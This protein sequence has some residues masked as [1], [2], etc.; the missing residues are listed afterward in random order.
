MGTVDRDVGSSSKAPSVRSKVTRLWNL[1]PRRSKIGEGGYQHVIERQS[2]LIDLVRSVLAETQQGKAIAKLVCTAKDIVNCDRIGFFMVE[3]GKGLVCQIAPSGGEAGWAVEMGRGILGRVAVTGHTMR[4]DDTRADPHFDPHVDGRAGPGVQS[5]LCVPLLDPGRNEVV[6]V[7]QAINKRRP[8]PSLESLA[9]PSLSV[10]P[11]EPQP[12]VAFDKTDED[13]LCLLLTLTHSKLGVL[14]LQDQKARALQQVESL[15]ALVGSLSTRITDVD[16][17]LRDLCDAT[18]TQLDCQSVVVYFLEGTDLVCR[19]QSP[20]RP[21]SPSAPARSPSR[22][23]LCK[24]ELGNSRAATLR[25]VLRSG[26]YRL[27]DPRDHEALQTTREALRSSSQE[28]AETLSMLVSPLRA[29]GNVFGIVVAMNKRAVHD[30]DDEVDLGHTPRAATHR[31]LSQILRDQAGLSSLKRHGVRVGTDN[32][33][34]VRFSDK[35]ARQL[36]VLLSFAG[37]AVQTAEMYSKQQASNC[38]L[39]ALLSLSMDS[40]H[41][42]QSGNLQDI[43]FA[44]CRHGREVFNCD[45]FSFFAVDPLSDELLGWFASPS[46]KD[47]KQHR[48]AKDGVV[49][50]CVKTG[51]AVNIANAWSDPRFDAS[52]DVDT[53]YKTDTVLCHPIMSRNSNIVAALQCVNK[54]TGRP[55][56]GED[57]QTFGVLS[58][59]FADIIENQVPI[60]CV[61][62]MMERTDVHPDAKETALLYNTAHKPAGRSG[63][64]TKTNT[65]SE[66]TVGS[67]A[68]KQ[69]SKSSKSAH[70]FL[71]SGSRQAMTLRW[72]LNYVAESQHGYQPLFALVP[73]AF[74]FFGLHKAT[75]FSEPALSS[76]VQGIEEEYLPVPY[77]NFLHAFVTFHL[78]F[79]AMVEMAGDQRQNLQGVVGLQP[80]DLLGL[81]LAALGHDVGHRGSN[82]GF[83]I[84]TMSDLAVTYNDISPLENHHAAVT[85]ARL[86]SS[87][88]SLS[89]LLQ[90]EKLRRLRTVLVCSILRT[91]MAKHNEH[92]TWLRSGNIRDHVDA[93]S[94]T[95]GVTRSDAPKASGERGICESTKD[96]CAVVL[97]CADIGHPCLPWS[98]HQHFSLLAC[99]ELFEQFQSET[100]LGLPTLPFMGKDPRGP[101]QEMGPSQSGFVTFVVMPAWHAFNS[102]TDGALE[103]QVDEMQRNKDNWDRVAK[104]DLVPDMWH[105]SVSRKRAFTTGPG[106]AGLAE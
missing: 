104:G 76:F 22:V 60:E 86:R 26:T 73:A 96:L 92:V 94:D 50:W 102:F 18:R 5:L 42:L 38:R 24:I 71:D 9:G 95:V 2:N 53:G 23:G 87:R 10:V 31:K 25:E 12:V 41:G 8:G 14:T 89:D 48:C 100:A 4:V 88:P 27:L 83:E 65:G 78:V 91:D 16:G 40:V 47:L 37:H 28:E 43:I 93:A 103:A 15:L 106:E 45:R 64:R 58:K 85:W 19:A 66:S 63:T 79:L 1:L 32:D 20:Q 30:C 36:E 105:S 72:D 61:Y 70:P 29:R 90:S 59:M 44:M 80:I 75:G 3:P 68:R 82:N 52:Q 49:G 54:L 69:G 17:C 51:Q 13:T 56:D 11:M 84:A 77:H 81:F 55:F 74:E 34:A 39:R 46:H 67:G 62:S 21:G 57:E 6:A 33:C 35:D 98:T 7:M 97:H 101:P 99:T